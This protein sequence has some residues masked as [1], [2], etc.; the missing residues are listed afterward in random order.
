MERLDSKRKVARK[1]VQARFQARFQVRF[2]ARTRREIHEDHVFSESAIW[3]GAD[4]GRKPFVPQGIV[5]A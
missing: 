3:R 1:G 4:G 2:Q 5:L